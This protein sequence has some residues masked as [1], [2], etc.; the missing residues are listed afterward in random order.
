MPINAAGIRE[1][2]C[3]RKEPIGSVAGIADAFPHY[4]PRPK[5]SVVIP[6]LNEEHN[7][8]HVAERMPEDVDE[9]VFVNGD[10]QDNTAAVA[11][12]LWPTGVHI[13][14]SRR[15]KG[16]ALAC[17]IAAATGDIIV[18]IDADGS[19]DPAEI[20]RYVDALMAGADYAKGSRFIPGGGSTDITKFRWLGNKG[21]NILVNVLFATRFTDL[22]YGY[23]AFWRHCLDVICLPDVDA[24]ETQ[25]G[26]G[27]EIE[28]MINTRIG[29]SQLTI[30]EVYSYESSRIYG[31]SN[32]N[33]IADGFRVLSTICR[34]FSNPG[35]NN[36]N[37][38]LDATTSRAPDITPQFR[39]P[40]GGR[41][42][43]TSGNDAALVNVSPG[44]EI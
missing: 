6:A 2:I 10:S 44:N 13:N 8:R 7:L 1:P 16:N 9:V 28:T 36:K 33:A 41:V 35:R 14:Q 27:F 32:L 40:A 5:V 38:R 20:P 24:Q 26:D 11:R 4:S 18:T 29:A 34:E 21:L 31:A 42:Q 22:C 19:T 12:H 30:V 43:Q 23:N 25:W 17:G 37:G 3:D 15:G 39:A